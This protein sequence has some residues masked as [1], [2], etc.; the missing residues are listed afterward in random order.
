MA[1]TEDRWRKVGPE[2]R[3]VKTD[4]DGKGLRWLAVWVEPDGRRRKKG[5]ATKDAAQAH[6]DDIA[7]KTRSGTYVAAERGAITTADWSVI[8][9]NAQTHLKESGKYTTDGIVRKHIRSEERR[10]GKECPV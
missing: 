2:G 3:K 6:L 8:W 5:F 1:H 7:H 9:L 10:V 4:R